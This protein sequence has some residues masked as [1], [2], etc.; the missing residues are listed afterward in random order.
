MRVSCRRRCVVFRLPATRLQRCSVPHRARHSA[1]LRSGGVA[2]CLHP[3]GAVWG[4]G[5]AATAMGCVLSSAPCV[6]VEPLLLLLL[7]LLCACCVCVCRKVLFVW[8]RCA[9]LTLLL[10]VAEWTL[11]RCVGW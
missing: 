1:R 2:T 4:N 7:L 10:L 5:K 11:Q 3:A 8:V 6:R 9:P